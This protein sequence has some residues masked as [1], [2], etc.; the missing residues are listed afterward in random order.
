MVKFFDRL[1][2]L[3]TAVL[4]VLLEPGV[5]ALAEA[6][7]IEMILEESHGAVDDC[8]GVCTT[9]PSYLLRSPE[10]WNPRGIERASPDPPPG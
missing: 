8:H 4:V 5:E 10:T 3:I 9:S 7:V 6:I 2:R 1:L